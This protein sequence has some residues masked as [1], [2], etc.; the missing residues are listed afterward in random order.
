MWLHA[1]LDGGCASARLHLAYLT[2]RGKRTRLWHIT[3]CTSHGVWNGD[4]TL[5]PMWANVGRVHANAHVQR[6]PRSQALQHRST[7]YGFEE[8]RI[9]W[10]SDHGAAQGYM[11]GAEQVAPGCQRRRVG[12][13]VHCGPGGVLAAKKHTTLPFCTSSRH[14]SP[15]AQAATQDADAPVSGTKTHEST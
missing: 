14:K 4:V 5:A 7:D 15:R 9:G 11:R 12:C 10:E 3:K 8:S 13:L 6:L 2:R 1:A